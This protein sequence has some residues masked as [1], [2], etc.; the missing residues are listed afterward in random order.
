LPP[1]SEGSADVAGRVKA[2]RDVQTARYERH[3]IR[4]NAEADGDLLDSV[5]TPDERVGGC[6]PRRPRRCGSARAAITAF[7]RRPDDSRFVRS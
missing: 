1:P 6:S 7:S 2:A 3:G 4:T 5:A